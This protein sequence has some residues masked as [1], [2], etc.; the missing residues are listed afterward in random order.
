MKIK[1]VPAE[2]ADKSTKG[3]VVV[4]SLN[5]ICGKHVTSQ[6]DNS[7]VFESQL[8]KKIYKNACFATGFY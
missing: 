6:I 4:N 7:E 5:S 2:G 1:K 3:F 8:L